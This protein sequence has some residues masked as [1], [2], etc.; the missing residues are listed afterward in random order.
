[1]R[2]QFVLEKF[3]EEGDPIKDMGIG[4]ITVELN[5]AF[6]RKMS[7]VELKE[8]YKRVHRQDHANVIVDGV[9]YHALPQDTKVR[10]NNM[11]VNAMK[12][13]GAI[14]RRDEVRG[15][16]LKPGDAIKCQIRGE[17]WMDIL[18][19]VKEAL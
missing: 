6:M 10:V 7:I 5:N 4:T 15:Q 18:N 12:Y 14:E 11:A 3:T 1:M 17:W 8:V 16:G 2:A 19:S 13:K 9:P